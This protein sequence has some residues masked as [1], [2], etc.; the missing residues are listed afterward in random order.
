MA[1][2]GHRYK[3]MPQSSSPYSTSPPNTG[4]ASA[5]PPTRHTAG[6]NTQGRQREQRRQSRG[7]SHS[8]ASAT[9]AMSSTGHQWEFAGSLTIWAAPAVLRSASVSTPACRCGMRGGGGPIGV[10]PV[11]A[12]GGGPM[13]VGVHLAG[14][15][16]GAC[17]GASP[18]SVT[19]PLL[20]ACAPAWDCG[21]PAP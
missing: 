1:C 4:C 6:H 9:C 21:S 14:G 16:T 13:T 12:A 15:P 11:L 7:Q 17:A 2:D 3:H 10:M 8:T 19:V 18:V 20:A 5:W